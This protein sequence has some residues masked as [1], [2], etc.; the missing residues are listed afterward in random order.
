MMK[1]GV[2]GCGN[3]ATAVVL[4]IHN[5]N[6]NIEFHC[7]TPS[8]T[9]ARDLAEKVNGKAH[10]ELTS[11]VDMDYWIVACK[12]QQ[13]QNLANNLNGK[14][15]N[16]NIVSFL[17]GTTID[18]LGKIF[19]SQNIIRIMPNTPVKIGEGIT[20]L[21]SSSECSNQFESLVS[22]HLESC[23]LERLS[24]IYYL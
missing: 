21:T 7:Y 4:G 15:K 19:S 24:I 17:A 16:T 23:V 2:L 3:M 8:Y 12:P 22:E 11:F 9:R 10:K 1:I 5:Q 20:L 13:V 14:L 18:N 6:K